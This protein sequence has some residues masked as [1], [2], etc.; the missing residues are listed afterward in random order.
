MNDTYREGERL[1]IEVDGVA[2]EPDG[3]FDDE[4]RYSGIEYSVTLDSRASAEDVARLV[5][6]VDEVAE[7]PRAIRAGGSVARRA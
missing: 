6:V 7:I 1:D 4:W 3:G 2:V 5:A